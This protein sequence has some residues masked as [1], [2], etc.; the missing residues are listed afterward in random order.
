MTPMKLNHEKFHGDRSTRFWEIWKG[1]FNETTMLLPSF[2]KATRRLWILKKQTC[3]RVCWRPCILLTSTKASCDQ[4]C[5]TRVLYGAP[6]RLQD[7]KRSNTVT[8]TSSASC[9]TN[10]FFHFFV[11][12]LNYRQQTS[13]TM[14]TISVQA[15]NSVDDESH[16][17]HYLLPTK[18]D[19]HPTD[20]TSIC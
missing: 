18:R 6:V 15:N 13:R 4:S 14:P 19:S 10:Y 12:H 3:R 20:N 16:V 17:V 2:S 1:C 7:Y 8:Q 11:G 9:I 5:N